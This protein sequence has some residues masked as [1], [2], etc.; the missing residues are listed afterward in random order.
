MTAKLELPMALLTVTGFGVAFMNC[1]DS[2]SS[3]GNEN[4]TGST[5]DGE[6]DRG[7]YKGPSYGY[8]IRSS[9]DVDELAGH[10]AI[11]SR[12]SINELEPGVALDPLLQGIL[13]AAEL[14]HPHHANHPLLQT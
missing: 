10:T 13:P 8:L 14:E 5:W 3:T 11:T 4:E 7:T 12:L 2:S 6:C 1:A 9:Q